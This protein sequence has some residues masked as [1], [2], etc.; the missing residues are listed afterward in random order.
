VEKVF[1][2]GVEAAGGFSLAQSDSAARKASSVE[3]SHL[4]DAARSIQFSTVGL[5]SPWRGRLQRRRTVVRA[6][7][8]EMNQVAL[9]LRSG[10]LDLQKNGGIRG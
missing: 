4:I 10:G 7:G 6:F 1:P 3:I 2:T 5:A 8:H 9:V